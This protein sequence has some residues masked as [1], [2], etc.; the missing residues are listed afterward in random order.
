MGGEEVMSLM[1][2]VWEEI[3][4]LDDL[5]TANHVKDSDILVCTSRISATALAA[6]AQALN[7]VE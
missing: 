2:R 3:E 5:Y 7:E 4:M 1:E 6:I